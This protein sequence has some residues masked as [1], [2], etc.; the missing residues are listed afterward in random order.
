MKVPID[1]CCLELDTVFDQVLKILLT[2]DGISVATLR[3]WEQNRLSRAAQ[4]I[5]DPLLRPF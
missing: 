5:F 3:N 4:Q 2:T 1:G